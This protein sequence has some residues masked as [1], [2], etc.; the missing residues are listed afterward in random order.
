MCGIAGGNFIGI[1][2][3]GVD[4]SS[5]N[6]VT[7]VSASSSA[8]SC[9]VDESQTLSQGT[10]ITFKGCYQVINFTGTINITKYPTSNKT[11]YLDLDKLITVGA[12]S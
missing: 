3:A 4:N 2:G 8:G 7:S 12:A 9:V 1:L 11:I 5:A 10:V 6:T